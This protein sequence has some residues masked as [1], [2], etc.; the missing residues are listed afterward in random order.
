MRYPPGHK[1]Q[2]RGR[3]VAAASRLFRRDG[4]AAAGV[5]PVMAE[6]GLTKGA[7]SAHFAGKEELFAEVLEHTLAHAGLPE[8]LDADGVPPGRPWLEA[9]VTRYLSPEHRAAV[10]DGCPLPAVL[11]E[12]SRG[13]E[14]LRTR[15][16]A[17]H[18]R[19]LRRL[20]S[21]LP[22]GDTAANRGR[23]TVHISAAVGALTLARA[24]P[25]RA[26]H[27]TLGRCREFL[28]RELAAAFDDA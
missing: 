1:E 24:L 3:I 8:R 6:A 28:L 23:V 2:T 27:R 20:A 12:V 21:H 16:A 9:F 11:A 7:F 13:G 17:L 26:A 19:T 5:G 18:R 15:F 14:E 25:D 4:Y 22:G 10:E